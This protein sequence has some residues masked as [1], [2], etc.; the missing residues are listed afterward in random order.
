MAFVTN[1]PYSDGSLLDLTIHE[2]AWEAA[3]AGGWLQR[4]CTGMKEL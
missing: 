1:G 4:L 3:T 2:T